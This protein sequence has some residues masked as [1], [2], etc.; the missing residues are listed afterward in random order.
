MIGEGS[1]LAYLVSMTLRITEIQRVLK[2]TGSFWLH[3]DPTCSHYLK[4][5]SDAVFCSQKGEFL[6]EIVWCYE[7]S[8]KSK[9][10]FSKKHDIIFFYSKSLNY[11]FNIN[12]V[13]IPRK[14]GKHMRM[15]K[16]ENGRLYEEKTDKKSGKIYRWYFD[17]GRLPFDYWTDIQS[18]NREEKERLGYPTQK[19]EALL[20]R[21]IKASTDKGDLVL[22]AYCG[23]GTTIAVAERLERQWT[24]IDIIYQSISLILKRLEESFGK[25]VLNDIVLDGIPQDME[26]AIALANKKDD[27][28]RKEFEKWAV[29]TY[30]E[31]RAAISMKKGADKGID[32]TA[33]FA[34]SATDTGRIIFQVKSGNVNRSVISSLRGDMEREHAEMGILITLEE[35]TKAMNEEAKSAGLYYHKLMGRNYDRIQIVTVKEII[36]DNRRLEMPLSFDVIKKAEAKSRTAQMNIGFGR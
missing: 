20:E 26:A 8:G 34:A 25:K 32:G 6:N 19:P 23:C 29:L 22:D 17:E 13:K 15:A 16:D 31:N 27:R 5:I 36:Q 4:L 1:L 12:D 21:I 35:P 3:C 9:K 2:Q 24:G 11:L 10:R 18:M 28:L 30:S 33:Y 14:E 7:T